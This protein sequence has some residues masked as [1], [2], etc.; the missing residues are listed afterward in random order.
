MSREIEGAARR[1]RREM[2][3]AEERLWMALRRNQQKGF[4]F[5]RQHPI[6]RFVVDFCCTRAKLCIEVDGDVHDKQQE[7]DAERA[8]ALEAA[9]YR[10]LR[11]CNEEVLE[12]PHLVVRHIQTV[13]RAS[14]DTRK[15]DENA[16]EP[17]VPEPRQR[18]AGPGLLNIPLPENWE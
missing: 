10:V 4:Y 17:K 2:T 16:R 15:R 8:A 7:H 18:H 3:P 12:A 14:Q 6:D 11:F 13:L 5:R 1:L 9:G